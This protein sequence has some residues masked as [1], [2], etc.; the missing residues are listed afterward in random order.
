MKTLI[1][2]PCYNERNNIEQIINSIRKNCQEPDLLVVNDGSSDGS[3]DVIKKLQVPHLNLCVN[4]G[5]GGAIQTGFKYAEMHDYDIAVQCDG[6]GQ[7]PPYQIGRLIDVILK[8]KADV[9]IGSRFAGRQNI[10][11]SFLRRIGINIFTNLIHLLTGKRIY[12]TTS[13]FRAYSKRT[14]SVLAE[15][16]PRDYPEP[17]ALVFLLK[18]GFTIKEVPIFMKKRKEGV[19]SITWTKSVYYMLKVSLAILIQGLGG[20]KNA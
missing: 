15:Y 6:D 5:I 7:H 19:S 4:T 9:A 1:I 11:F 3:L 8:D 20:N 2:I 10:G 13:G 14:I 17:E 16:Y 12:D 18:R